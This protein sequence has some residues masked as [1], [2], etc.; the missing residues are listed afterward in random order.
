LTGAVVG[1][2]AGSTIGGGR[3]STVAS[4]L[5]AVVGG[6][7]GQAIEDKNTR[8]DGLEIT[9]RLEGGK[10]TAITQEADE[11]FRPGDRV[12]ILSGNGATRVTH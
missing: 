8:K 9:V 3:G 6:I 11:Q 1:G 12:R 2:I 5:G 10:L 7:A 4:V